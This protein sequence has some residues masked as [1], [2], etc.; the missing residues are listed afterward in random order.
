[1][2]LF[3]VDRVPL[4]FQQGAAISMETQLQVCRVC[5]ENKTGATMRELQ[6]RSALQAASTIN[7]VQDGAIQKHSVTS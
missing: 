7:V 5:G 3:I 2:G 6:E 4:V 1:M